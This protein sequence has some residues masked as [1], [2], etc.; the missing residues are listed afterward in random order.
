MEIKI[1]HVHTKINYKIRIVFILVCAMHKVITWTAVHH[2]KLPLLWFNT[3][4]NSLIGMTWHTKNNIQKKWIMVLLFKYIAQ[5][6]DSQYINSCGIIEI[7]VFWEDT[8]ISI[9][10]VNLFCGCVSIVR[11]N[12]CRYNWVDDIKAWMLWGKYIVSWKWNRLLCA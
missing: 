3:L 11:R 4:E 7:N 6:C 12:S 10:V 1:T 5:K 2:N 8:I 9:I